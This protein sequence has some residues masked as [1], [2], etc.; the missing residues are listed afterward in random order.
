MQYQ[1]LSDYLLISDIDGTL[2]NT[3]KE[4]PPRNIE[5]I[6]RFRALGGRFT[7]ATGRSPISAARIARKVGVNCP[8]VTNNGAILYDMETGQVVRQRFLPPGRRSWLLWWCG[9]FPISV[10]RCTGTRISI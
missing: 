5:A 7:I 1:P 10:F 8:L 9:I 3:K 2:V 4:I 6:A